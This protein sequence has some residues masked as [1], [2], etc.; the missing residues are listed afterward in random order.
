MQFCISYDTL[1]IA[2]LEK[3]LFLRFC[4]VS[5]LWKSSLTK[6]VRS[7]LNHLFPTCFGGRSSAPFLPKTALAAVGRQFVTFRYSTKYIRV[8]L[9]VQHLHETDREHAPSG[10]VPLYF[11]LHPVVVVGSLVQDDQDFT[12]LELKLVIVVRIAVI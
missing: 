4:F 1:T 6:F 3:S 10:A 12:L 9:I 11:A 8:A 7:T 2:D 5:E